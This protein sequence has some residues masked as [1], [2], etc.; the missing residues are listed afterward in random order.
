[1]RII[2]DM[3]EVL[4]QFVEHVLERWN[5][6][7]GTHFNRDDI[8]A[9]HMEET[10][11]AGAYTKITEWLNEPDFFDNLKPIPGAME[12]VL[13][14]MNSGHDVV[15]ATTVAA[16]V[17]HAFDGKRRSLQR[18]L[19]EFNLK[20]LVFTSR[21]GLLKGDVL[22]DDGSHNLDDWYKAGNTRG[23]VMHARWNKEFKH[24]P[25]ALDWKGVTAIIRF[26]EHLDQ[27]DEMQRKI[28]RD[29]MFNLTERMVKA[30]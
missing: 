5:R 4:F 1:M 29:H 6:E 22:I 2:V 24:F 9:W 14:L 15:I 16:D 23:I 25:R 27:Y 28:A 13:S 26:W 30:A 21:K 18:W 3:D 19:P 7:K 20:N 12:G 17:T 10:L 8:D 11:G